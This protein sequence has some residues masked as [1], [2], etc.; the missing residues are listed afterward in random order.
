MGYLSTVA[1]I[2]PDVP[3][4]E[5]WSL[6]SRSTLLELHDK[7]HGLAEIEQTMLGPIKVGRVRSTGHD[8]SVV[9]EDQITVLVPLRGA[10]ACNVHGATFKA[11][12]NEALVLSPNPRKT[13]VVADNREFEAIPLMFPVKNVKAL[14]ENLGGSVRTRKHLKNFGLT[15]SLDRDTNGGR[16]LQKVRMIVDDLEN[17]ERL[18]S[19]KAAQSW[20]YLLTEYLV[21]LLDKNSVIE[22]PDTEGKNTAYRHV[23]LAEDYMH[24]HFAEITTVADIAG[25]CGISVRS[26]EKAFRTA[27]AQTPMTRLTEIRL[28]QA[29]SVLCS[30]S[31]PASVTQTAMDCG[32]NHLG[33]FAITYKRQY[34]E[35]P[36]ETMRNR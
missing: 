10:V 13:R 22:L 19:Q 32:F 20:S 35:T 12:A 18:L 26:L 11:S 27:R 31:G 34:G 7:K 4:S 5:G 33:R 23:L 14:T 16:F 21:T 15:L 1:S 6:F 8:I 3:A 2:R 30:Q 25:I 29:R 24:E 9:V 17:S 36:S 28:D